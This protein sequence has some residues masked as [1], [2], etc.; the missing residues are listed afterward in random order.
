MFL[1]FEDCVLDLG[2]RELVRASQVVPTAPQVFDLL[3]Y[4]AKCHERVVSRDE[5]IDAIWAGR[6]V[7]ESTLAS[8]INAVRKAVGDSGQEQRVIRTVARKGFRF[9]A[10]LHARKSPDEDDGAAAAAPMPVP[11]PAP[12]LPVKPSI[13]VLPFVNL[14][15]DPEQDYLADGVIEDIIAALSRH[16][17]LFVVSRNSSFTYKGRTVDVKQVGRELGVRYVLEGSWRKAKDRVRI[18][19][20]LID[21]TT[22]AHHWAGRVEGV[23]GDI[24]E[25]QDQITESVIGAVAPELER[26]EME[27]ARHKPTESLDAYDYYLRGIAEL[28]RA[29]KA[30]SAQ[31][32]QFLYK[33]IASDPEFASAHAMAAWCYSWRK[34]NRWTVDP[35]QETAE[36]IRLARRAVDLDKGDA[37][38]LT[39]SGHAIGY[40]AGD[41]PAGIALLDQALFLNPNLAA[42]RYL[43]GFLRLWMGDTEAAIEFLTGAVRLSPLDPEMYRMQAGMAVAHLFEKRFD[44]ASSWA[45]KA[46]RDFPDFLLAAVVLAASHALAGRTAEAQRAMDH[47]RR[48]DPALRLI[49]VTSWLPIRRPEHV[50]ILLTGLADAG[51]PP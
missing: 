19:G 24:F 26:A 27:R 46:S 5:L 28:H 39:R 22:G 11:G 4:L 1:V 23:L 3:A 16:R 35:A 17:W 14:S 37:V 38:A 15:G 32:L 47:V 50:A 48:I 41:I 31:A 43:G 30:S 44:T 9:A 8:H 13:A 49:T 21:A 36:G 18:T 42:A 10:D 40:L 33:A 34:A 25:L 6:I 2:R 20:Q 7:S 45:E 12:T 51:L 29:S